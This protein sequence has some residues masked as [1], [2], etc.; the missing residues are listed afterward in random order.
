MAPISH[1]IRK[2]GF[3]E[4]IVHTGQHFDENMSDVFF[5]ELDIPKPDINLSIHASQHGAMTGEM[6][7]KL[8]EILLEQKPRTMLIYGDTN[9]T[10]AAALAAVKLH[11]P[12]AHIEA[13]PRIYDIDT[14]EEINRIVADHAALFRFC[15]DI[16]SVQ[17]LAKENITNGVYFTGDV[18]YDSFQMF[19][20]TA[21]SKSNILEQYNITGEFALLTVHRPNNTC[22]EIELNKIIKLI[23]DSSIKVVFPVHPRTENAFKKYGLWDKLKELNN[24]VLFPAV[25]YLDILQLVNN[26][27]IVLTDS[28]GLQKEA[29]FAGKP[30][31]I[32]FYTT[33]WPQIK[34]CGW[35]KLCWKNGID[36]EL[37]LELINSYIPETK[38]PQLF[39]D[40]KA[41]AKIIDILQNN[42]WFK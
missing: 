8:E 17:N 18:M 30:T 40:G 23:S 25:G 41:A 35:Q 3:N 5:N 15:P 21:A 12:I 9:S 4:F 37:A 29:F 36:V 33:P 7:G 20:E 19:S 22:N 34:E 1:E 31:V 11:I 27:K 13:G 2:R 28:G 24:C 26:S 38:R 10:L 39:G 42:G 16:I 6:L 32:L 14:P